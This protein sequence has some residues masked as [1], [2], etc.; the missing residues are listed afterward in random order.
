MLQAG[1]VAE[2]DGSLENVIRVLGDLQ[3]NDPSRYV[4]MRSAAALR[5][6]SARDDQ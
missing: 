3:H 5:Q 6:I 1:S 4:R 2:T